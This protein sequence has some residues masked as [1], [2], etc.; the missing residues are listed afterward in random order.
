M[1]RVLGRIDMPWAPAANPFAKSGFMDVD[2]SG[3]YLVYGA[4]VEAVPKMVTVWLKL[5]S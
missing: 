3:L 5:P 2:I 1:I 4:T